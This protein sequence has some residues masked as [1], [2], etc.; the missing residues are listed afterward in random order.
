MAKEEAVAAAGVIVAALTFVLVGV[1]A[2][3]TRPRS[4]KESTPTM[5]LGDETPA[6]VDLLTDDFDITPESV[7]ATLVDLAARRWLFIEQYGEANVIIRLRQSA[8]P[9]STPLRPY[10][11]QVLDHLERLAIDGVVPAEATT[12]GPEAASQRWWKTF[13]AAV[14]ADA[15]AADLCRPRWR[16]VSVAFIGI[17][18]LVTLGLAWLG[19]SLAGKSEDLRLVDVLIM[20]GFAGFLG[21]S[22][23]AVAIGASDRQRETPHGL[24]VAGRWLGVRR[25]LADN[26][27]FG[28]QGAASVAVWD[29]YLAHAVALDLAPVAVAQLPLGAEDDRH[30]WSPVSGQWRSVLVRYPR[31]RPGYGRHPAA[32]AA[33]SIL[34]GAGAYGILRLL[35][36]LRSFDEPR[37]RVVE[38]G[39][40]IVAAALLVVAVA[41]LLRALSDSFANT[42]VEGLVLRARLRWTGDRLPGPLRI[43]R[44]EPDKRRRR[45]YVAVDD[46]RGA[47]LRALRVRSE[48]YSKVTQGSRVRAVLTPR[49]HYVRSIEQVTATVPAAAAT[50]P[51]PADSNIAAAARALAADRPPDPMPPPP[52]GS[53]RFG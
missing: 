1:L 25:Y 27:N 36:E 14:V 46:G 17:G 19:S 29:R 32:V 34:V 45:Y 35:G 28:H 15:Q 4:P 7:P 5:E 52:A 16:G 12:T 33:V 53:D 38:A 47:T 3:A 9:G 13:R 30:A 50:E 49:L 10:E 11:K 41:S 31:Y 43:F 44:T 39:V 42:T 2:V 26:G 21:L 24:E 8:P 20:L 23:T 22:G 40:R 48:L 6:V 37:A 18:A 51:R